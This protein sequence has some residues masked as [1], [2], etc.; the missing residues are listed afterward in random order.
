MPRI[1]PALRLATL[2]AAVAATLLAG[3]SNKADPIVQAE[4]KD[5]AAGVPDP[6][7][8][9]TK[10]IVEEAYTHGFP[11][12]VAYKAMVEFN[13]DKNSAQY[14]APFNQI[15]NDSHTF[16]HRGA[17]HVPEVDPPTDSKDES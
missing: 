16:T 12:V 6:G 8:A 4:K 15:W 14:K 13:V 7:I 11:M 10:A 3:C 17:A 1:M 2:G 5:T 9:Q